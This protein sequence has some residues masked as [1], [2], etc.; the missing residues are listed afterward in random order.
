MTKVHHTRLLSKDNFR[1]MFRAATEG[2]TEVLLGF[3]GIVCGSSSNEKLITGY[4]K[5]ALHLIHSNCFY[6]EMILHFYI[7]S[8]RGRATLKK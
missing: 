7:L 3:W 5:I 6:Q 2:K 1:N 4:L 8:C